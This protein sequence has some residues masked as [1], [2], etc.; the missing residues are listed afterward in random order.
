MYYD[1]YNTMGVITFLGMKV[2]QALR[3][4]LFTI[5]NRTFDNN[6]VIIY[7]LSGIGTFMQ[8]ECFPLSLKD[9]YPS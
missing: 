3:P 9:S 4:S 7:N 8:F 5:T 2:S 6:A 1:L